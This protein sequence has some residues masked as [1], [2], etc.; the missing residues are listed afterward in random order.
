[1]KAK[2][3]DSSLDDVCIDSHFDGVA[4]D[5]ASILEKGHPVGVRL[6]F[7]EVVLQGAKAMNALYA[8]R[9]HLNGSYNGL[10]FFEWNPDYWEGNGY[11]AIKRTSKIPIVVLDTRGGYQ[12]MERLF[13][14]MDSRPDLR[15]LAIDLE[16]RYDEEPGFPYRV[17]VDK[18]LRGDSGKSNA[19]VCEVL[20]LFDQKGGDSKW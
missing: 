14:I 3:P 15:V 18:Y 11:G 7:R 19:T 10:E 6:Y 17:S 4:E 5:I 1:M 13:E 8:L 20:R 9:A 16:G 2:K 12:N